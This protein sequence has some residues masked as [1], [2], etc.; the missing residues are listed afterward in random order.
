MRDDSDVRY[1]VRSTPEI[2]AEVRNSGPAGSTAPRLL[3]VD[4]VA[5][6]AELVARI[7]QRCGFESRFT[8]D[9]T[10]VEGL[11]QDWHPCVVVTDISM[12]GMDAIELVRV[13]K[14]AEFGGELL[15]VSGLEPWMLE[16]AGKLATM[17]GLTVRAKLRKPL[18]ARAL[19]GHLTEAQVPA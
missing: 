14:H 11:I 4:D 6:S 5:D 2:S 1:Q 12:P 7:A 16:Q 19:R 17:R 13:L 18:D 8:C 10:A 3:A 15:I 9:P